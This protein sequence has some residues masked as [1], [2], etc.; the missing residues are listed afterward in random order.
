MLFVIFVIV[1]AWN[2]PL[3]LWLQVCLTVFGAIHI[4]FD[5]AQ[6]VVDEIDRLKWRWH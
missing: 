2:L 6:S 4:V 3:P 1:A 5:T